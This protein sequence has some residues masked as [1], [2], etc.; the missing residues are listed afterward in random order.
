MFLPDRNGRVHL[1]RG[2]AL[3]FD[4]DP[5]E[6]GI[7]QWVFDHKEPAGHGTNTL[8]GSDSVYL[9]LL[10]SRGPVGVLGVRS[11]RA[12]VLLDP[13]QL[14]LLETFT[15]QMA[16]ALERARL[17][18]ETQEAH[19]ETETERMRNAVLSSV[20]HDLRTPLASITGAGEYPHED[21]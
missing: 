2:D 1:H 3:Q 9:P 14:H 11:S 18:E 13:G 6:A 8:P 15:N 12:D 21:H 20:S 4:L 19:V 16:L 7:S 17:A 5:K 10:G